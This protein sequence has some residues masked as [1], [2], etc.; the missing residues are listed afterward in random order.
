MTETQDMAHSPSVVVAPQGLLLGH[1]ADSAV[2]AGR[3]RMLAGGP[4]AFSSAVVWWREAGAGA[5]WQEIAADLPG[6][7]SWARGGAPAAAL[8]ETLD[9]LSAPRT[10]FAGLT[11]DRPRV[12]GILNCTPDSFSDGGDYLDAEAAVASGLAMLDAGADLLDVGGEST[13]PGADPVAPEDELR[14]ILP[15]VR[16]LAERG[17]V[18]SVDT[19]R[20]TVMDAALAHGATILNDITA[21]SDPEALAVAVRHQAPTILMH[22]QG[23]PRTM[24]AAPV[25][26]RAIADVTTWLGERVTACVAAGLPADRLCVDPGIGFGKSLD[27][28]MDL[29]GHIGALHGLGCAVLLG[30]SRKSFIPRLAGADLPP[31]ARLPGSLAAALSAVDQGVQFLRV[32]DVPETVQALRVAGAAAAGSAVG[33]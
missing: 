15:V 3:A 19:R 7:A 5:A 8:A 27:H 14:R 4:L 2:T 9:H 30:A 10:S 23:E 17:V 31:K 20:A 6:L 26:D 25:Y 13:R 16:A 12:M 22:M 32:H 24:Q 29:L 28:N 11:L 21:L 18:V 33:A 1:S